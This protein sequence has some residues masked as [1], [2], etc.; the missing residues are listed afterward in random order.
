MIELAMLA[1]ARVDFGH[2]LLAQ[3][4]QG[5]D[6]SVRRVDDDRAARHAVDANHV[7]S[8]VEPEAVV[9]ADRAAGRFGD[10]LDERSFARRSELA[11]F[12]ALRGRRAIRIAGLVA[13]FLNELGA[14][15]DLLRLLVGQ[16]AALRAHALER[17]LRFVGPVALQV[18]LAVRRPRQDPA[19][20]RLGRGRLG[21][22]RFRRL[23]LPAE[24][25]VRGDYSSKREGEGGA[26][27]GRGNAAHGGNSTTIS[28]QSLSTF[29]P[30]AARAVAGSMI[31]N[32][33]P[34]PTPNETNR[35]LQP[36]CPSAI[37]SP[38]P[39]MTSEKA[40]SAARTSRPVS[41]SCEASS[42]GYVR[43]VNHKCRRML[44]PTTTMASVAR[45]VSTP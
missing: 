24:R 28:G 43:A 40:T 5:R 14:I 45:K 41:V 31:R 15:F 44:P 33:S 26:G 18:G 25:R 13:I 20:R 1:G 30:K 16:G 42:P 38:M 17:R 19:R 39:I 29:V 35:A 34:A 21:G 6:A 32:A 4:G 2:P 9:A 3:I 8:G 22:G 23:R 7:Q 36:G 27:D 12:A 11:G 10:L 37:S